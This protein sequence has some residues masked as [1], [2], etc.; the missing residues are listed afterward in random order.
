MLIRGWERRR[1]DAENMVV[2][3]EMVIQ[4]DTKKLDVVC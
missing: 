4:S 2:K 3:A 1:A